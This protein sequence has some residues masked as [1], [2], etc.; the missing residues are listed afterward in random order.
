MKLGF[1]N[2]PLSGDGAYLQR[3][4]TID[5]SFVNVQGATVTLGLP[6][7]ITT[8]AASIDGF[9][10]VLPAVNN[11]ATFYGISLRTVQ[12]PDR[13]G[14]GRGLLCIGGHLR[15]GYQCQYRCRGRCRPWCRWFPGG[16]LHWAGSCL[17][18]S[19]HAGLGGS[20]HHQRWRIWSCL[21]P[22][23]VVHWSQCRF[24]PGAGP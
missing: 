3:P 21:D 19:D 20:F 17:W 8:T 16:W 5:F 14:Q 23:H 9:S 18:P 22:R 11:L 12:Q 4:E 6:V 1:I 7:A 2:G 13:S 24:R 15:H 10:A